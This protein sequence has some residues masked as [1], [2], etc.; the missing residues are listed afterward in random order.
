MVHF[1]FNCHERDETIIFRPR[2]PTD[3]RTWQFYI[4]VSLSTNWQAQC[5][6]TN[7]TIIAA[8]YDTH[9]TTGLSA[10]AFITILTRPEHDH[11]TLQHDG[12]HICISSTIIVAGSMVEES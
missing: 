12:A 11:I 8:N 5:L 10:A 7:N 4:S 2:V 3:G 1:S 9:D 6:Q